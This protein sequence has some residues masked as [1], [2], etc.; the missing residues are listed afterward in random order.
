MYYLELI[1]PDAK[2]KGR[3]FDDADT[4]VKD[5]HW[6]QIDDADKVVHKFRQYARHKRHCQV[7]LYRFHWNRLELVNWVRRRPLV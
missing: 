5:N 1:C 6:E 2:P 7:R 4:I 3:V